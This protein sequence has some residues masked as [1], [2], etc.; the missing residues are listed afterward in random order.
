MRSQPVGGG[1]AP[2]PPAAPRADGQ[3]V[4]TPA[5]D[6]GLTGAD[7]S[8]GLAATGAWSLSGELPVGA[9]LGGFTIV[10][11]LAEGGM[12]RVY[13]ARQGSPR[14]TV[15]IK[16][17]REGIVSSVAC[18]RFLEEAETL[19]RLRHPHVAQIHTCG[20]TPAAFGG[21]P[22]FVMEMVEN[23]RPITRFAAS[24]GLSIRGRVTLF[25]KVCDAVA[26]GHRH[27][28]VHL[29]LKPAN[30]LVDSSGEPKVIDYGIARVA[31]VAEEPAP[32]SGATVSDAGGGGDVAGPIGTLRYMSPE[33]VL[34]P[35]R[36]PD[37]R[38]DVY[39]LGLVLHELVTGRLPYDLGA[40]SLAE[41]ARMLGSHAAPP[42]AVVERSTACEER[43]DDARSLAVIVATCLE[44]AAADRYANAGDLAA[45]LGRWLDGRAIEA[46][47]PTPLESLRRLTRRHRL[48]VASVAALTATLVAATVA[49]S[50]LSWRL[51]RQRRVAESARGLATSEA[52]AAREQLYA[53]TVLLAAAARDRDNV[54]EAN[55]LLE[56]ARDRAAKLAGTQPIELA[57]LAAS[58]DDAIIVVPHANDAVTAVAW[59]PDGRMLATGD[60]S[61]IVR[62]CGPAAAEE[63]A[64]RTVATLGGCV[65]SVAFSPDGRRIAS[66]SADGLVT[67]HDVTSGA[68]TRTLPVPRESAVYAVAFSPDGNRLATAS[69]DRTARLWDVASGR[70]VA[71]L[72]GHEGTV[73]GVAISAD[74]ETMVTGGHDGTVRVWDAATG[75]PRGT[76]RG[77]G[78]RVFDVAIAADGRTVA[79][80]SEDGTVRLWDVA[81]GVETGLLRHPTRVNAVV[82]SESGD[83]VATASADGV[84]RVWDVAR[85]VETAHLRGRSAALWSVAWSGGVGRLATGAEDGTVRLWD[86]TDRPDVIPLEAR[87]LSVAYAP[88]G[89]TLAIG[90]EDAG[91][92]LCD[93][94]TLE[95][96]G[97]LGPALGRVHGVAWSPDGELVA[98]ACDDGAIFVW[99]SASRERLVATQVHARRVYAVAFD[100]G[101]T[102]L[103][104]ASEDRTVRFHDPRT[105]ATAGPTLAHPRRVF[106]AAF[107]IDGARIATA[108]EDRLIR[109]WDAHTGDELSRLV[110]HEGPV[111][112]V[113]YDPSGDRLASAS[114]DGTVRVW[115]VADGSVEHVLAGPAGQVWKVAFSPDGARVAAA[116]AD[117]TVHLWNAV[118]GRPALTLTGHRDQVWAVAFAPDGGSLASGAW[119]GTA[120]VWGRSVAEIAGLRAQASGRAEHP[121]P[122]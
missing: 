121:A 43:R 104:T 32:R 52:A 37:A 112:W 89:R 48:A 57:C 111:N 6:A 17:I 7:D 56:E 96:Y 35:A 50:L 99:Q 54:A 74:G 28:V 86:A 65:W 81:V 97:R 33:Q 15:A 61:G 20:T 2:P 22:F 3:G 71:V 107:S 16:V 110:G 109:I 80:A 58:L 82:F 75:R 117:G 10:R 44:T 62:V 63:R 1:V 76:L 68:L 98:G 120:R 95:E 84:L 4:A 25:R 38:S 94:S 113:A 23:A 78:D 14:R 27:G 31:A 42:T 64:A 34:A 41:A 51:E 105:G 108:C 39:A 69:R 66:S 85:G 118:T 47:P 29:D 83:R 114:S 116:A 92:R 11:L 102:R 30:I 12:G 18:A 72:R 106:C 101:G 100:P 93:A 13:E 103:A 53:S 59:S 21:V 91:I 45:D 55:H 115:D 87:T 8:F 90:A 36:I 88:D 67:L 60:R 77:H 19:A 46:R 40:K 49:V 5:V 24:R 70:E 73:Y 26:H 79:S 9:D 119:D 122:R